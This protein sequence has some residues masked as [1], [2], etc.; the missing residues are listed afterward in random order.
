MRYNPGRWRGFYFQIE[1]DS[2]N[3]VYYL[4]LIYIKKNKLV[5]LLYRLLEQFKN[6]F[7]GIIV[8]FAFYL[9]SYLLIR[10]SRNRKCVSMLKL[11]TEMKSYK[12]IFAKN[13]DKINLIHHSL[14]GLFFSI[15]PL[16]HQFSLKKVITDF[17]ILGKIL[18]RY[19]LFI[20]LRAIQ[21]LAYYDRFDFE[22]HKGNTNIVI[23]FTD[24]NPHGRALMQSALKKNIKLCFIS[25]GEPD[26]TMPPICCDIA[27]LFGERSLLRYRKNR[28]HI[29]KVLYYGH[30]DIFKKIREVD[31]RKNV[32]IGIFLSKS[33]N[34]D[35]VVKLIFLLKKTF[36]NCTILIRKHP[37]MDLTRREEKMLLRSFAVQI[38]DG[39]SLDRDIEKC[40]FVLAGETTVHLD[41][42]L[43]GRPSLYYRNLEKNFFYRYDY[44]KEEIILEWDMDISDEVINN[45]YQ[46]LNKKNWVNFFLNTEK[47]SCESIKEI[48]ET[49]F[50]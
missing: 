34:L 2:S 36:K 29:G 11:N 33:T 42:L 43:R 5:F 41:V 25:H 46:D 1:K 3:S 37:N 13:C 23:V 8:G 39:K 50:Q 48:N 47:D 14:L 19:D 26:E 28:S 16:I 49:I 24:A 44:V 17:S 20:A 38:S 35:E 45:F 27:Y 21:Y 18:K 10:F 32:Q 22:L 9:I 4:F 7:L 12:D 31:F 30:K 6:G 15:K 40:D